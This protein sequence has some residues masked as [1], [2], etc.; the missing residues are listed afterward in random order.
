MAVH[1]GTVNARDTSFRL[2][3]KSLIAAALI[4]LLVLA[5]L[6]LLDLWILVL[7]VRAVIWDK[8]AY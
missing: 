5:L 7:T 8:D 3:V 2:V 6:R 4:V 1:S